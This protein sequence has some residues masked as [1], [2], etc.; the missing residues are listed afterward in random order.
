MRGKLQLDKDCQSN[1][2]QRVRLTSPHLRRMPISD[3][4]HLGRQPTGDMMST[5]Q[6]ELPDEGPTCS[7]IHILNRCPKCKNIRPRWMSRTKNRIRDG[8]EVPD[9]RLKRTSISQIE[10]ARKHRAHP[11]QPGSKATSSS[12]IGKDLAPSE[13]PSIFLE[14]MLT[15]KALYCAVRTQRST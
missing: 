2:F 8:R 5:S 4:P 10:S 12:S 11:L 9:E 6:T 14:E 1:W 15:Q 7:C 13:Y 3:I